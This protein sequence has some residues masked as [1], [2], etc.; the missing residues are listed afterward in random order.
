MIKEC[1]NRSYFPARHLKSHLIEV[2]QI[3][4]TTASLRINN[5][6]LL[7]RNKSNLRA[8]NQAMELIR[9]LKWSLQDEKNPRVSI[10]LVS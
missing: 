7:S 6:V 5:L 2:H 9:G 8:K 3:D 1:Q 10:S 4:Q